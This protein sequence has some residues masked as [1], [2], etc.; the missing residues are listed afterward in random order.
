MAKYV[1]RTGR[2]I[3]QTG[4]A[5][6]LL[7]VNIPPGFRLDPKAIPALH[8][9]DSGKSPAWE[10]DLLLLPAEPTKIPQSVSLRILCPPAALLQPMVL[11]LVEKGKR[12]IKILESAEINTD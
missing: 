3:T 12:G 2:E 1:S 10:L 6:L 9:N 8:L 11:R 4:E 5:F 7:D